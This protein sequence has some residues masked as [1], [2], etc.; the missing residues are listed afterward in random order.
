MVIVPQRWAPYLLVILSLFFLV[1]GLGELAQ[2][3]SRPEVYR[4]SDFKLAML[5]MS[6]GSVF[7]I[8]GLLCMEWFRSCAMNLMRPI[9]F[10]VC[11]LCHDAESVIF[12]NKPRTSM[13]CRSCLAVWVVHYQLPQRRPLWLALKAE[14]AGAPGMVGQRLPLAHWLQM[15]GQTGKTK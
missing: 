15:I 6:S 2:L 3:P 9:P 11:P 1:V 13:L 12:I 4:D 14:T 10:H 8:I 5:L 7:L